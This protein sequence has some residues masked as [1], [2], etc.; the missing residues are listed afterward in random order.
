MVLAKS[1]RAH[2][3]PSPALPERVS[4]PRPRHQ[5]AG[6]RT[7]TVPPRRGALADHSARFRSFRYAARSMH[8]SEAPHVREPHPTG[9]FAAV[10]RFDYR[11]RRWLPAIGLMVVVGTNV[12]AATSGGSLIQGGWVIDGSQEQH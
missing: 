8:G 6:A 2:E 12:W 1:Y 9:I 11:F 7:V 5:P 4:P 10:G 3:R